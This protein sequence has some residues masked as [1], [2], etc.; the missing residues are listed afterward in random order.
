MEN[1]KRCL[2]ELKH[3]LYL[4]TKKRQ[5]YIKKASSSIIKCINEIVINLLY[6]HKNGL[7]LTKT[8]INRL[9]PHQNQMK[10]YVLTK[11]IKKKT[12]LKNN[13]LFVLVK[14]IVEIAIDLEIEI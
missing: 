13:L 2:P 6:S 3:I 1:L 10:N 5:S 9:K 11:T 12:L 4:D 8:Q 7:H 14:T